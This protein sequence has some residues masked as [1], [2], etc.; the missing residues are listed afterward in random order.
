MLVEALSDLHALPGSDPYLERP[1]STLYVAARHGHREVLEYLLAQ[2]VPVTPDAVI[3]A[4]TA[5]DE[6]MLDLLLRSG[7]NIDESL[8]PTTPSALA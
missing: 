3:T 4:V 8:G 7:W 2:N 5:K 1:G 6:W